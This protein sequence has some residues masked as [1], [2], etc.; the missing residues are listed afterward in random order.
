MDDQINST[1]NFEDHYKTEVNEPSIDEQYAK[2]S[3]NSDFVFGDFNFSDSL[4]DDDEIQISTGLDGDIEDIVGDEETYGD[5]DEDFY[6][7]L[8]FDVDTTGYEDDVEG[9]DADFEEIPDGNKK[10]R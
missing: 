7:E 5:E 6:S 10:Q 9:T 4:D 2:E 8:G 3:E 1:D